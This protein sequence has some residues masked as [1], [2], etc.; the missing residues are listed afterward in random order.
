MEEFARIQKYV[1]L[2]REKTDFVP[3]IAIVLGS[4][5]NEFADKI[6]VVTTVKYADLPGFPTC[7]AQG[8][9]G[10]FVFGYI[11]NIKVVIMQGRIHYYEGYKMSDVV[12]PLRIMKFLGAENVIFTNAAGSMRVDYKPS[13]FMAFTD[14]IALFVPSPLIGENIPQLGARFPDTT[15]MFDKNI[16]DELILIARENNIDVNCGVYVQA[17]G[18]QYESPAE[19]LAFKLLGADAVG[20]ST[21][22]ECIAALQM[23]MKICAISCITNYESGL[24]IDCP[25]L[26]HQQVQEMANKCVQDMEVLLKNL[27]IRCKQKKLFN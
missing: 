9:I 13:S 23:N 5:L 27:I 17:A 3:E 7:S 24:N 6:D 4:G 14:Q 22:C 12:L 20:M 21:A 2:I 10:Q 15:A 8:H 1:E 19:M 26:S 11:E 18:P 16:R 25:P